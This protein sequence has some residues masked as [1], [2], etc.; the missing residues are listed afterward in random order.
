MPRPPLVGGEGQRGGSREQ[1]LVEAVSNYSRREGEDERRTRRWAPSD[2]VEREQEKEQEREQERERVVVWDNE[3]ATA[4]VAV[5]LG[6]RAWGGACGGARW[7]SKCVPPVV[8][9]LGYGWWNAVV[10]G[11]LLRCLNPKP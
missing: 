10:L 1:D 11:A 3:A 9:E 6:A 8:Q 4:G 7:S 5:P 2:G